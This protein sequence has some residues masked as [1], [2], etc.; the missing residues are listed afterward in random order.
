[1]IV[2]NLTIRSLIARDGL[3]R[4]ATVR[5]CFRK[6]LKI[7]G[8]SS[9]SRSQL[10]FRPGLRLGSG[11]GNR[12]TRSATSQSSLSWALGAV[13]ALGAMVPGVARAGEVLEFSGPGCLA[14]QRMSPL[15]EKLKRQGYPIRVIDI[16]RAPRLAR[17][18][19]IT[20][21]PTFVLIESGRA[22]KKIVGVTSE[23]QL[24]SLAEAARV[25][26]L[27]QAAAKPVAKPAAD[28]GPSVSARLTEY[29]DSARFKDLSKKFRNPA[30]GGAAP[31]VRAKGT[32]PRAGASA[33]L[34]AGAGVGTGLESS[35]VRLRLEQSDGHEFASGTIIDSRAGRSII[36]TCGHLFRDYQP[37]ERLR[38]GVGSAVGMTG[39]GVRLIVD[40]FDGRRSTSYA[41]RLLG[42]DLESDVGLVEISTRGVLPV[43]VVAD[44]GSGISA[45]E[46]LISFG[47]NGG[48][49]PTRELVAVT[50]LNRYLGP[51]NVECTGV[52]LQGRSGGGLF[53]SAGRVVG[54]C[55][56][57]DPTYQRGLYAGLQPIHDLLTRCHL[58]SLIA[59]RDQPGSGRDAILTAA[60]SPVTSNRS[61][62]NVAS[63]PPQPSPQPS[64][65]PAD[66]LAS[67]TPTTPTVPPRSTSSHRPTG[68]S[69]SVSDV[70]EIQAALSA[71]AGAEVVCIIRST[72]DPRAASRVV[73]IN[74][75]SRKFVADLLGEVEGGARR[76]SGFEV[77]GS[78][79]SGVS[80][81][82]PATA[83]TR[84]QM[85][86]IRGAGFSV[87]PGV[88]R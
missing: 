49:R 52:P 12:A 65:Q 43:A 67:A 86:V 19:D 72:S 48:D 74:R 11:L 37:L 13:L 8:S 4:D 46:R 18:L 53:D 31:V 56:A 33:D 7:L 62:D 36:L 29:T 30:A 76:T 44:P 63:L 22:V 35:C 9:C 38:G 50:R 66:R 70:A 73:I 79:G 27:K 59:N 60:R 3:M 47:C 71:A 2:V 21:L 81:T 40:V 24:R 16:Q 41:G 88:A 64:P 55:F 57:A 23:R 84:M 6:L 75:A 34:K 85:P 28:P 69:R 17:Q 87:R 14:C 42:H 54:V 26:S 80:V 10:G 15:V 39:S 45:G 68:V 25:D 83:A 82:S 77:R 32:G 58:T 51:D 61:L 5:A 20:L 1:M 78:S